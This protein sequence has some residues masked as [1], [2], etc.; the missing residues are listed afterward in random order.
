MGKVR[1]VFVDDR[2]RKARFLLVGHGGFL[3]IDE[4]KSFIPVRPAISRTT[5]DD[6]YINDTRDHVARRRYDPGLVSVPSHQSSIYDYY[7]APAASE[8]RLHIGF[9]CMQVGWAG[10]LGGNDP[11]DARGTPCGSQL[12]RRGDEVRDDR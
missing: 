10:R 8:L 5:S 2:E 3:E 7:G 1:D 9:N 11:L 6:V 12:G 4:N